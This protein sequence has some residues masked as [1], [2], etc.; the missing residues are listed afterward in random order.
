METDHISQE[1]KQALHGWLKEYELAIRLGAYRI[2]KEAK[3]SLQAL[4][5]GYITAQEALEDQDGMPWH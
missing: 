2:A 4:V 5:D 1:T 3:V